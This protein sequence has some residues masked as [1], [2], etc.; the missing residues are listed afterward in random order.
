MGVVTSN[1]EFFPGMINLSG[2]LC[3]MNSVLQVRFGICRDTMR[4]NWM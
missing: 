1:E 2:V 3:Y 4:L